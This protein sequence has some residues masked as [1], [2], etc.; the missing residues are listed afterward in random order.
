MEMTKELVLLYFRNKCTFQED[1]VVEDWLNYSP[2]NTQQAMKW[3]NELSDEEEKLFLK[4]VLSGDDVWKKTIGVISL[5]SSENENLFGKNKMKSWL[6]IA[7]RHAQRHATVLISILMLAFA[8]YL[9]RIHSIIEIRTDFGKVK[10]VVLP[11]G[12]NVILNGN[13]RL[14]Y[15]YSWK[16]VPREVWLEGE[17]FFHVK[18]KS[19]HSNFKVYL[20]GNKTIE[21]LGT[22]FN[23]SDRAQK[24]SVFLKSGKIMLHLTN[25]SH[26]ENIALK[27]GE[28]FELERTN[29]KIISPKKV[30][31]PEKYYGWT[32]S[33][34]VLDGT[35]LKEMLR[36][37]EE[38]YGVH[39]VVE[40]DVLMER[41][42]SGSIP[43]FVN[44]ADTLIA[45]IANLFELQVSREDNKIMLVTKK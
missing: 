23:V 18:R 16:K 3:M 4:I 45:D 33:K 35:S 37:L 10:T 28:L 13:S 41:R 29:S 24:S 8:F 1:R 39:V 25:Q 5:K 26:L 17:A 22:E 36:K 40:N 30:S 44:D 38:D 31:N 6:W 42:V 43:L 34:W 14:K 2:A 19:N 11:D 27:P 32:Q 20:P 9:Y 12:S 15:A 21:V 7:Y